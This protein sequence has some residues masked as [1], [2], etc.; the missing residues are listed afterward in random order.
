MEPAR[1]SAA[2]TVT[3]RFRNWL[4]GWGFKEWRRAGLVA[5]LVATAAFGGL[6]TVDKKITDIK[7]GERFDT[8]RFEMTIERATLVDAVRAGSRTLMAEKPGHRYLGLVVSVKNNGTLPGAVHNP[9]VLPRL[10]GA[11]LLTS[12]R[13]ADGT[14]SVRLGPGLS[15]QIVVLW[16]VAEDA[17]SVG[18]E[19]PV[20]VLKEVRKAS[21]TFGQAWVRN[22]TSY[23]RLA[24]PVGGPK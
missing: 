15:D 16:E 10:P 21:V 19:L 3:T 4:A 9:L 8:G 17:I 23:G 20:R 14:I 1:G 13:L 12:M 22:E 5:V 18:D 11:G 7:A 6:D 24:V 2:I